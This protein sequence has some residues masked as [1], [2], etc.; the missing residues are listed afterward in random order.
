M[1]IMER[2][3]KTALT[4]FGLFTQ[5]FLL[6]MARLSGARIVT[7][8]L[9]IAMLKVASARTTDTAVETGAED[10]PFRR[11]LALNPFEIDAFV[12]VTN[13]SHLVY[14]TTLLDAF[15]HD[16]TIFLHLLQPASIGPEQPLIFQD[17]LGAQSRAEIITNLAAKKA[18]DWS[19]QSFKDRVEYLRKRFGLKLTLDADTWQEVGHL[20]GIRNVVVHTQSAHR[21]AFDRKQGVLATRSSCPLHPKPVDHET[22]MKANRAY[23]SLAAEIFSA[24]ADQVLDACGEES[25]LKMQERFAELIKSTYPYNVRKHVANSEAIKKAR[26]EIEDA[27]PLSAVGERGRQLARE[28]FLK[29]LEESQDETQQRHRADG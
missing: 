6:G 2:N 10:N 14:A 29:C 27:R 23:V 21:L 19:Y 26:A 13:T 18:R 8:E 9:Q 7:N 15:I 12:Y 24:V 5:D 25:V 28:A 4:A 1:M 11:L 16:C 3:S 17:I 22:F 20:T